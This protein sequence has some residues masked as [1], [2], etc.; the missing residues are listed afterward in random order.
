MAGSLGLNKRFEEAVRVLVGEDQFHTLRNTRGFSSA[1]E[2]FDSSV[3]MA[4]RG[5]EDER[6]FV[7]FPMAKLQDDED[8]NLTSSCWDM[9]W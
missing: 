2:Q 8:N 3:K 5:K 1:V 9:G 4:F 7:N 6:Y